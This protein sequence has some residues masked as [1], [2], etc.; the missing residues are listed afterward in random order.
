MDIIIIPLLLLMQSIVNLMVG[1]VIADVLLGWLI[2][3]NIFNTN[4]KFVYSII[5]TISRI[6]AFLLN[7]IRK[8]IP[9]GFG[10]LDI[11]PIILILLLTFIEHVIKR[12]LL[13]F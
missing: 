4:N 12:V 11:S 2:T 9:V 7:P 3:A 6:S 1:I 10:F 13:R 5:D 8:R